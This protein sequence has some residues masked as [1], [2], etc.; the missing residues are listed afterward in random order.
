MAYND[1]TEFPR[2]VVFLSTFSGTPI[3]IGTPGRNVRVTEG[4]F[5]AKTFSLLY[6][7]TFGNGESF[8]LATRAG[9]GRPIPPFYAPGG[10][11]VEE[12]TFGIY[13]LVIPLYR[14]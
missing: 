8:E 6:R 3:T 7:F 1:Q 10:L 5:T 11:T 9:V 12:L 2:E 13:G 4:G 14:D